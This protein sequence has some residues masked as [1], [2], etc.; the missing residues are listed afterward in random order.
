MCVEMLNGVCNSRSISGG[1]CLGFT[2]GWWGKSEDVDVASG[3]G[4]AKDHVCGF[5]VFLVLL[6][7]HILIYTLD[8]KTL[9]LL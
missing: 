1:A 7:Y 6:L 4:Q 9:Y 5:C 8:I 3:S 2:W